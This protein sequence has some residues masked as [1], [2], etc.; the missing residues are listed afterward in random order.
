[1]WTEGYDDPPVNLLLHVAHDL[2]DPLPLPL[3]VLPQLR[4]RRPG[5]LR[6]RVGLRSLQLQRFALCTPR[7]SSKH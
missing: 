4:E 3:L 1:M 5:R 6:R 7:L 2:L